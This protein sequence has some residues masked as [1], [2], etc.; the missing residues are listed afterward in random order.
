MHP[1]IESIFA[2]AEKR[3]L[4]LEELNLINQYVDSLPTRLEIYRTLRDQE[5]NIMQP[6][7]EQLQVAMSQEPTV[8]LEQSLKNALLMLRYCAM[9]MLLNDE[10]FVQERLISWLGGSINGYDTQSADVMIY[11]LLNQQLSRFFRPEQLNLLLPMLTMAQ[12]AL[13]QKTP[14]LV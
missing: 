9:G 3:Y 2:E 13:V 14:A 11:Q 12:T 5:L 6:I 10:A 8:V 4:N 1:Q 7:A